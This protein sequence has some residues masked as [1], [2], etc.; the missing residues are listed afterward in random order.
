MNEALALD[1]PLVRE[2]CPWEDYHVHTT[3]SQRA[4]V[5]WY[6]KSRE[7]HSSCFSGPHPPRNPQ[8]LPQN[9]QKFVSLFH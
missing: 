3:T 8:S 2:T 4:E 9:P 6:I 5:Q 1:E 7:G